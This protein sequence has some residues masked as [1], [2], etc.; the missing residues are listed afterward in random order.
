MQ[1][2]YCETVVVLVLV[3]LQVSNCEEATTQRGDVT[4]P[5]L[6]SDIIPCL[7]DTNSSSSYSI[8]YDNDNDSSSTTN[9]TDPQV[10]VVQVVQ[11]PQWYRYDLLTGGAL[12]VA[13]T[14]VF[15]V[16]LI[17]NLLVTVAVLKGDRE[18]RHCVTNIFLVN[19]AVADLLVIITCLP[20]TLITNLFHRKSFQFN[21]PRP[22][23]SHSGKVLNTMMPILSARISM[24]VSPLSD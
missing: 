21:L 15:C 14:L 11:H 8:Y 20:F 1:Y 10:Q 9:E 17:G 13:Y 19:L 24:M 5:L 12:A 3:V 6:V 22:S 23:V 2:C 16:G 18:M 7:N 4:P